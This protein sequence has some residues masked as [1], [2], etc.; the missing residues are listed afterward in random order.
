M[1][2]CPAAAAARSDLDCVPRL[3]RRRACIQE[4]TERPGGQ[5]AGR[6]DRGRKITQYP[7]ILSRATLSRVARLLSCFA[8]MPYLAFSAAFRALSR[9]GGITIPQRAQRPSKQALMP[10]ICKKCDVRIICV[11]DDERGQ[12]LAGMPEACEV[13]IDITSHVCG[14]NIRRRAGSSRSCTDVYFHIIVKKA[15][16]RY[17]PRRANVN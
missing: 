14:G 7:P 2:I 11:L 8:V 5:P 17:Y 16:C 12:Q 1:D 9:S 3:F 6:P 4:A 10:A 15:R 13:T